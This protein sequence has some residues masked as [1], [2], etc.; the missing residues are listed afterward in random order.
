MNTSSIW[1]RGVAVKVSFVAVISTALA[2]SG[3]TTLPKPG[4]Y[5]PITA[6]DIFN[7]ID[8]ELQ[9][10]LL[11]PQ[12]EGSTLGTWTGVSNVNVIKTGDLQLKAGAD[13]TATVNTP[14][15]PV[16]VKASPAG[17][18]EDKAIGTLK[19]ARN[20][21]TLSKV[22]KEACPPANSPLAAR[23]LGIADA[24]AGQLA[25]AGNNPA[26]P[27]IGSLSFN[28]TYS[29]TRGIGGGLS[30]SVGLI[31]VTANGNSASHEIDTT[32]I[33]SIQPPGKKTEKTPKTTTTEEI[34]KRI[35]QDQRDQ[36]LRE[37]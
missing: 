1:R 6:A 7:A 13:F 3:C 31:K 21:P 27:D 14:M 17:G 4:E 33:V 16:A 5:L 12:F 34:Q 11:Q 28:R 18:Y 20:Y 35:D 9:G 15:A 29:V 37:V 25:F 30:F 26:S 36:L 2:L 22:S 8:C 19:L 10:L 23:G 32:I 24:L